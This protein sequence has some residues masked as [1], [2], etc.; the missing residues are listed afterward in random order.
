MKTLIEQIKAKKTPSL[1]K[2]I[3]REE[4][5]SYKELA[6]D[7]KTGQAVICSN[8]KHSPKKPCAVGKNLKTKV[9]VNLG[10]SPDFTCIKSELKKLE[11]S[12]KYGADAVMDLSTGGNLR[13]IRRKIIGKC[14]VSIGTVPIYETAVSITKAKKKIKDLTIKDIIKTIRSQAED[15]VDFM[16]LHCGLTLETLERL[17]NEGRLLNIVSRGGAF[18][19]NWMMHNNKENPLYEHYDELLDILHDYDVTISLG[20][21]LRPGCIDDATD[22]AQ[23]Q[24]LIFLGELAQKANK[25]GVQAIIEGPGHV[26]LNEIKTNMQIQKKLCNNAPFYVLGPLVTDAALGYDHIASSIGAAIA[27]AYG[28][29]FI[30]YLTPAEHLGLPS[31]EDVREGLIATRIAAHAGDIAQGNKDALRRDKLISAA[32]R[33]RDFPA[34]FKEA[35]EPLKA[36]DKYKKLKSNKKDVCSMCSEFCA[37]KTIEEVLKK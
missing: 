34:Q 25:K 14:P 19:A 16:T 1:V 20:D 3:A 23:I 30:C 8:P 36:R 11:I 35:I 22:R 15:G 4:K 5:I 12:L 27:A 31:E 18:L 6:N 37:I 32:R 2:R 28:A 13:Q 21:G 10:T 33:K 24:E 9:N 7:I 26:P 29:D 17:K